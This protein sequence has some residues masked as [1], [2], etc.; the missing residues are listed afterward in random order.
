MNELKRLLCNVRI[1][2]ESDQ[3]GEIGC[4]MEVSLSRISWTKDRESEIGAN[5]YTFTSE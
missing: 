4:L 3:I 5:V 2:Q 1:I